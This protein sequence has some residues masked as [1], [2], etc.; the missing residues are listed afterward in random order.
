MVGFKK[1]PFQIGAEIVL[2]S[3]STPSHKARS[4]VIGVFEKEF[5]MIEEPVFA[6]SDHVTAIVEDD[7]LVAYL[8]EGYLFT[9][10]SRFQRK[11]IRN[12]ICIEYPQEFQV[13]QLRKETRV[14]VNLEAKLLISGM[15]LQGQVTDLSEE[16]CSFELPK[17]IS[18]F[19]GI[20]F[21]ATFTLPNDQLIQDL[22]CTVSTVKYNQIH[23][24][25]AIGA[26]FS[27]PTDEVS[28]IRELVRFCMR[29]RV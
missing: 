12:I 16:G 4:K 13:E 26:T 19:K 1:I 7:F 23:R 28:T 10:T 15:E 2:R 22:Q 17:I 29:F 9:F 25:T 14:R 6:I 3:P 20:A 24:K 21:L 5:I 8:Y 11:L 18:L 27:G